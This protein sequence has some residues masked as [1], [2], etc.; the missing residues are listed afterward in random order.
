MEASSSSH[1]Q[2]KTDAE[3]LLVQMISRT[4]LASKITNGSVLVLSNDLLL[5]YSNFF[6]CKRCYHQ[7]H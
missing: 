5:T 2:E 6:L 4:T 7:R 3:K 1:H